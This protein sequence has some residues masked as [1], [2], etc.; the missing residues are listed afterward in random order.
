MNRTPAE[1][2]QT[3]RNM[4]LELL[5]PSRAYVL[6]LKPGDKTIDQFGKLA[7]VTTIYATGNDQNGKAYACYYTELSGTGL[8]R[9]SNSIKEDELLRTV[10]LS[11]YFTSAECDAIERQLRAELV[12]SSD[13]PDAPCIPPPGAK[14][15]EAR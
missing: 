15:R 1:L 7:R 2:L 14:L 4:K 12:S 3:A 10:A 5:I 9:I 11:K 13:R 8:A 6:R